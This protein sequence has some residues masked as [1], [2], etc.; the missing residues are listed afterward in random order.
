MVKTIKK[1][2]LFSGDLLFLHLALLITLIIRYPESKH[3]NDFLHHW[4]DFSVVFLIWLVVFYA[5]DLYNLNIQNFDRKFIRLTINAVLISSIL[6]VI[7][8]YIIDR[9]TITP[10][11]NLA[12]FT[13]IFTVLFIL[14]RFSYKSY[15]VNVI[16][17]INL[18]VIGHNKHTKTLSNEIAKNPMSAYR[19]T[20][21]LQDTQN[22]DRLT[23]NVQAKNIQVIVVCDDFG[24]SERME[25]AL[26]RC[27]P[28]K[29]DF[30]NYPDFY[31]LI[32]GK[33]PVEA[34]GQNWFLE[35]LKEGQK[36]YYNFSKWIV[37]SI[38]AVSILI[39]TTPLWLLI[40]IA[41]TVTSKG[42]VFFRQVRLGKNEKPFKIIKFRTMRILGNDGSP[43]EKNDHRITRLGNFLRKTRLDE[44]PQVL[45]VLMG[46]M[47]FIGPRP[48]RPELIIELERHI[49]FYKTRLL[50][51]P[52]VTGWDQI[53][54]SYH[55][56][57]VNDT[58]EKLQHDLYYLKH[59]SLYF[60]LSIALKT[61][62][63]MLYHEGR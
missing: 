48:E 30:F 38:L 41:I 63:T 32:T 36:N 51:K 11:T 19:M 57:S 31:E 35:N 23:E 21:I 13:G 16:P 45:N 3:L 25:S 15:I 34:I 40:G 59:R 56:P 28:Y 20:M 6:S 29:V 44:I 17:P 2:L 14:W 60:D 62:A 49:P 5:L 46:D 22:I 42:P 54:G 53:S 4:P 1:L 55:S 61:I 12:V 58:M 10:K 33:I 37:D 18:A 9:P 52:G 43:T 27:L 26:F 7:Y 39:I 8:F 47:S 50:I 24:E